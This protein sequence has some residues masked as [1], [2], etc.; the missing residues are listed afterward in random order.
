MTTRRLV[1][2]GNWKMNTTSATARELA[3]GVAAGLPAGHE[4]LEVVVAPPFPY[5]SA[6]REVLSETPVRWGAQNVWHEPPGAYTGEV[7][8][9]MLTDLGCTHVILGHSERRHVLGE[10]DDLINRKI[11]AALAGGLTVIFCVGELLAE[12]EKGET[13]AVLDAQL[14]GGLDG[15]RAAEMARVI[16]AYEPV[17]AIGTGK[18]ATP[19]QAQAAHNHLR[20]RLGERYNTETAD[21]VRILYG[22]SVK[23]DN[24]ATLLQCPDIDGA[25]VGGASLKAE[26]FL[27]IV[28]AGVQVGR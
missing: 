20:N 1:I 23:P 2:A 3:A 11:K 18:T 22:G 15:I 21:S 28:A 10:T 27:A 13:E 24:A 8:V 14:Q 17:W 25:L 5:L 16:V 26:S 7:A 9:E 19:E 12:R 6:V 4:T